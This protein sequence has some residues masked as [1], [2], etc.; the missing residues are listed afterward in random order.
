MHIKELF[1]KTEKNI[2]I[3]FDAIKSSI[4]KIPQNMTFHW[5]EK[6]MGK[7]LLTIFLFSWFP[8]DLFYTDMPQIR[9]LPS[10]PLK[11]EQFEFKFFAIW[12][13]SIIHN[14]V[15]NS[16]KVSEFSHFLSRWLYAEKLC[17]Q[18]TCIIYAG[19][20]DDTCLC[21]FISLLTTFY[22]DDG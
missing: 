3:E 8:F 21:F 11:E 7:F 19:H 16:T 14:R 4:C 1:L 15:S 17:C 12:S 22:D 9:F 2:S 13:F 5:I 6:E 10:S 20:V 18:L